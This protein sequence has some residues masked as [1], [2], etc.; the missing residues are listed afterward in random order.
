MTEQEPEID[1]LNLDAD[2]STGKSSDEPVSAP[3]E[4]SP[5]WQENQEEQSVKAD[6]EVTVD[7]T[8]KDANTPENPVVIAIT[9]K[10]ALVEEIL[11][12]RERLVQK[13]AA[14]KINVAYSNQWQEEAN[15]CFQLA[16]MLKARRERIL[17]P[18]NRKRDRIA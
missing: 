2:D 18:T 4:D 13:G 8:S 16:V 9:Q 5:D 7:G 11:T 12:E 15:Q 6:A 14:E 3:G 10:L 17:N 1:Q